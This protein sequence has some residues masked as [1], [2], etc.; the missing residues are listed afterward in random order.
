MM[1]R[2]LIAG[3]GLIDTDEFIDELP[4]PGSIVVVRDVLQGILLSEMPSRLGV[5][6]FLQDLYFDLIGRGDVYQPVLQY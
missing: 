4:H 1:S 5:M 3:I 6:T 2:D